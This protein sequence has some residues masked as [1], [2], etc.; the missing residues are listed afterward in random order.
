MEVSVSGAGGFVSFFRREAYFNVQKN[1][2]IHMRTLL[3]ASLLLIISLCMLQCRSIQRDSNS[4]PITH[5]IWD[6][7]LK[8]H[9]GT[10]GWV[11]YEG[12]R[13]DSQQLNRYLRLLSSAHPNDRNWSRDEQMAYWINAYNAFTVDIVTRHYPTESIKD[14]QR[15]VPFVNTVWDIK[16]IRIESYE[17]DLN[18]I[19]HNILRPVFKDARV[20]AAV[21]C[22]SYSCPVLRPEAYTAERL[23]DQ[24]N[25]SMKRFVR[26]PLR[27]QITSEKAAVSSIFKWFKGDFDRDA[28]SVRAFL[29]RYTEAPI[30]ADTNVDYLDYDWRLNDLRHRTA[31][32]R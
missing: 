5:E 13:R 7:L 30:G 21:N 15:G 2:N 6:T 26:D 1:K 10:D 14:I 20:H 4:R 27:N 31:T 22:A 24:L 12:F 29:S 3:N 17:Y 11:D 8:K 18:N 19:E 9:V 28:G 16:F 25:D 23:N 32:S